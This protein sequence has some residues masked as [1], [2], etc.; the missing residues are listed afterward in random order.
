MGKLWDYLNEETTFLGDDELLRG[1]GLLIRAPFATAFNFGKWALKPR[2]KKWK[3]HKAKPLPPDPEPTTEQYV[4]AA[5]MHFEDNVKIIEASDAPLE[6]KQCLIQREKD[7][8][9]EILQS[10]LNRR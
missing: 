4:Q 8:L 7:I 5:N 6:V 3:P 2:P 1:V 10:L 9:T